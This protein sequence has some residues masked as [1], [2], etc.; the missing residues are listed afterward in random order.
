MTQYTNDLS[1]LSYTNK[2]FGAIYPELLDVVR[3]LSEKWDPQESNES[4]PGVV[5]LK[6]NALMA[7]KLNYNI[8]KNIL[9]LFPSSVTQYSNAREI[10]EQC[11]YNMHHYIGATT[12]VTFVLKT[13]PDPSQEGI[14]YTANTVFK[15]PQFTM[16]TNADNT[17]V[18][19]TTQEAALKENFPESVQAIEGTIHTYLINGYETVTLA[20]IDYNNRLYFPSLNVAQN[21]IFIQNNKYGYADW[22]P[23]DNLE[24]QKLGTPCYKFGVNKT[25]SRCYIEFPSDI[26]N[27]IGKGLTIKYIKTNGTSGNINQKVLTKF[28]TEVNSTSDATT[29]DGTSDVVK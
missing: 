8:D 11:G 4:D 12:D 3:K 27:L 6:L 26:H 14:E 15:I 1:N 13:M 7:D 17:V 5:L 10:F 23:V 2:D 28:Y 25:G 29:S 16:V 19:T 21:G 20:D 18:Y 22:V 24:V 9:E